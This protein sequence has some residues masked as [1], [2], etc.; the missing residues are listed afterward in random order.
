[1]IPPL[2]GIGVGAYR[3]SYSS[4]SIDIPFVPAFALCFCTVKCCH[5]SSL[6]PSSVD[7]TVPWGW[8]S[9]VSPRIFYPALICCTYS[10][11]S[12]FFWWRP[13][14]VSLLLPPIKVSYRLPLSAWL[15]VAFLMRQEEY[16][17]TI[18]SEARGNC[19]APLDRAG[20]KGILENHSQFLAHL[21]GLTAFLR[22]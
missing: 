2:L 4:Y 7:S 9:I 13:I 20:R 15:C 1:M 5:G 17:T 22:L 16:Q 18:V 19:R 21:S 14:L 11:A 12:W 6:A 10:L 3:Y 8:G